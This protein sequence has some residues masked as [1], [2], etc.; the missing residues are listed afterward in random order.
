LFSNLSAIISRHDYDL[1]IVMEEFEWIS[2]ILNYNL[3]YDFK[4]YL[5]ESF[6][7]DFGAGAIYHKFDPGQ[8]EPTSESS[9]I[10]PLALDQKRALESGVYLNAE[11]KLGEGL[12][13]QYGLRYSYFSRF[14][15][16]PITL[17]ANDRP[18]VYNSQLGIYRRAE[19]VGEID[20]DKSS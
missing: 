11:H 9:S 5:N 12:T 16:Q 20:Y 10:N 17:Y 15:G 4:Y 6:S 13:A 3:K 19:V 14:G 18:V 2:S 1:D 8:I 7:L